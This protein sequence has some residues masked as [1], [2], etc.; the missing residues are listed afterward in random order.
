[1]RPPEF[2]ARPGSRRGPDPDRLRLRDLTP[3]GGQVTA[4][5]TGRSPYVL[6][7]VI[8]AL[9][10][11]AGL[12]VQQRWR[13]KIAQEEKEGVEPAAE[14]RSDLGSAIHNLSVLKVALD[15]FRADCG[16]YPSTAEGLDSLARRPEGG[17]GWCG[18]YIE[19][20]KPDVWGCPHRYASEGGGF[21]VRSDGPDQQPG[22]VDDLFCTSSPEAETPGGTQG[23]FSV[24][25]GTGE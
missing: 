16:R 3:G 15:R 23:E 6:M 24:R 17:A 19:E 10:I 12:V 18:P 1:M 21:L 8:A 22:T 5:L 13:E 11:A 20:L 25:I 14:E 9:M 2:Y 4:I 7:A